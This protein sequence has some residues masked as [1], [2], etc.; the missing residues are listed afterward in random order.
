MVLIEDSSDE[1][2]DLED[3]EDIA[4]ILLLH[5]RKKPK[6]GG[7]VYG[8][9][10]IQRE[11][12]DADN[13]LMR[14][15]FNPNPIYPERLFSRRFRMSLTLFNQITEHLKVHGRF[16][17]QKRNASGELGHNRR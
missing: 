11:R 7:L 8:C 13:K 4:L 14:N 5:K 15:Y 3:E 9:E 12:I 16:F 10:V 6:H 2:Y 1:E 17:V